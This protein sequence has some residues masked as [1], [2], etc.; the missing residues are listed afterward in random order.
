MLSEV[1]LGAGPEYDEPASPNVRAPP[2]NA[3]LEL[4]CSSVEIELI[5]CDTE[6]VVRGR[7]EE[8]PVEREFA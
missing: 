5:G 8:Q 4:V 2:I 1:R 3:Y 7:L 6:E